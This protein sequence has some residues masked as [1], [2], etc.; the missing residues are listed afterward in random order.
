MVLHL[1]GV[2]SPEKCEFSNKRIKRDDSI[3][4]F[5]WSPNIVPKDF[6]YEAML[7]FFSTKANPVNELKT[8]VTVALSSMPLKYRLDLTIA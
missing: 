3:P 7:K 6:F 8:G 1:V 4:W 2:N 5:L